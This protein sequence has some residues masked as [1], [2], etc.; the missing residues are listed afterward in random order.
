MKTIFK[1]VG[2]TWHGLNRFPPPT[3]YI[4]GGAEVLISSCYW[5]SSLGVILVTDSTRV[6]KSPFFFFLF[7]LF[8]RQIQARGKKKRCSFLLFASSFFFSPASSKKTRTELGL[9]DNT[10]RPLS[11]THTHTRVRWGL[12]ASRPEPRVH[13]VRAENPVLDSRV[14]GALTEAPVFDKHRAGLKVQDPDAGCQSKPVRIST[15]PRDVPL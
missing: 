3:T 11:H 12:H 7:P 6:R 2:I 8:T 13:A 4:S 1:T 9:E 14:S 15:G 10:R 5:K